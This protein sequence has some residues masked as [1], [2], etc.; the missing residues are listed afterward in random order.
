MTKDILGDRMKAQYE[1]RTRYYLPRRT[2]T[3]IRLDGKSFHAFT[4]GM[5]KPFDPEFIKA[6]DYTAL[7]LCKHLMGAEF[8][9]TQSDEI[10]LLLTDFEKE[11]T[12]AWFDGN[13]Q[14]IVSVSASVVTAHFN[15][16]LVFSVPKLAYFDSRAFTIP[17][18]TEVEN[19]FIWRQKDAIRN[20][21]NSYAQSVFSHKELLNKD[22]SQIHEMLREKNLNWATDLTLRVKNGGLIKRNQEGTWKIEAASEFTKYRWMLTQL[23]PSMT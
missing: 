9:Y 4:R 1:N 17:D 18:P 21:L 16:S 23:I 10:S 5:E 3:I 15:Q 11:T 2:Y 19:Y 20:S 7:A 12:D 22:Q 14:K 8:A 6:I 13:L